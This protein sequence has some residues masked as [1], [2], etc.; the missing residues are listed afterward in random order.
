MSGEVTEDTWA[1]CA[2]LVSVAMPD[3]LADLGWPLS[4]RLPAA[5]VPQVWCLPQ[6]QSTDVPSQCCQKSAT[7]AAG[8]KP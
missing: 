1:H 4:G 8:T 5:Q 7:D 6:W 3:M 2:D